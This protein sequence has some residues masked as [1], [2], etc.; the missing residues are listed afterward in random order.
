MHTNSGAINLFIAVRGAGCWQ[1]LAKLLCSC[2]TQHWWM[3]SV[4]GGTIKISPP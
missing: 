4:A 2:N 3:T 1:L